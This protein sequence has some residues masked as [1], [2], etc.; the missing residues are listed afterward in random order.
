MYGGALVL[1]TSFAA[2]I[3]KVCAEVCLLHVPEQR[4][5]S[6]I[7]ALTPC[8]HNCA[9]MC[10][11]GVRPLTEPAQSARDAIHGRLLAGTTVGALPLSL[12]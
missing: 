4:H 10:C 5:P 11:A 8:T 3:G 1:R 12:V 9:L 6:A 7:L 2:Q